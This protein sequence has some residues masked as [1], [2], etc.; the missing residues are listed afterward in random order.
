ML[1]SSHPIPIDSASANALPS[2]QVLADAFA[3]FIS[4]SAH[5]EDSY[6][7]L[8]VEVAHLNA[9]LGKR[10][11][12][13]TRS[14]AENDRIRATLQQ[15]LD[16]MPC[17]VLVADAAERI[18]MINPEC[19][20]L[21]Q[22]GE[23][24]VHSVQDL[25]DLSRLSE[26]DFA[27]LVRECDEEHE[28]E[29]RL[30]RSER[31]R[32]LAVRSRSLT[33]SGRNR[34]RLQ[35]IWILRDVTPEIQA[36]RDRESARRS[37]ALAEIST[38]LAHEI[39]NPLAS[40]E[41]F[42]GLIEQDRTN[43]AK[44]ITNLRAGIRSLSGTVNN[45]L[46]LNNPNALPLAP[47]NLVS[48]VEGGVEFVR[49]IAEQDEI[50]LKFAASSSRIMVPG[51]ENALQQIVLNIVSNAIRFTASGG[52]VQVVVREGSSR[53]DRVALVSIADN[54]CGIPGDII[55]HIFEPGFSGGRDSPG[56]GLAV[57]KRLA[58]RLGGSIRVSSK[59]D[60]GTTFELEFPVL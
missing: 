12:A 44:W 14:L 33:G 48:C 56:L 13:L 57:C 30:T 1:P 54:G 9:E 41:L 38:I 40:M 51:N 6:K 18:V 36:E 8:Q 5:L 16:S 37:A 20:K 53:S 55:D 23:N 22:L 21:L 49:P 25:S 2:P 42:A 11:S 43:A 4:A 10:N 50:S 7:A 60:R 58:E 29:I 35:R 47:V 24:T 45:V 27:S 34:A 52:E 46:N 32:W 26:I 39:R 31:E 17:G 19:S 15:M 3:E 59:V 28:C